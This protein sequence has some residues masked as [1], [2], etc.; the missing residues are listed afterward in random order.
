[1]RCTYDDFDARD[2]VE[3]L[4]WN[5]EALRRIAAWRTFPGDLAELKAFFVDHDDDETDDAPVVAVPRAVQWCART[6]HYLNLATGEHWS[7]PSPVAALTRDD[8]DDDEPEP[9]CV[10]AR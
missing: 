3:L 10:A 2:D 4:L 1:M 6:Q 9:A 7:Q 5:M 8:D